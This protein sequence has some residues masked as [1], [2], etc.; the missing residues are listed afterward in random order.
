[1]DRSRIL[2]QIKTKGIP[3]LGQTLKVLRTLGQGGN[4]AA[5]LCKTEDGQELVAKIYLPPDKRE[6]DERALARFESEVKLT[7]KIRHPN[8]VR[9]LDS[10]KLTLGAYSLPFYVMPRAAKTLRDFT[11][12]YDNDPPKIEARMR[13]FLRAALGVACL[14]S[15]GIVHRD[16]K[17][18]N[19]LINKNGTP[20]V[21]DLGIAHVSP[22][23]VSV[24]VKTIASDQL[25]NRDYYA[26]E[27]RFGNATDV[28]TRADI[29]ALG[30]ILY[31]L[32]SGSPPVRSSSPALSKANE[33]FAPLDT[34]FARMTAHEPKDRYEFLEDAIEE[35]S[36]TFGWV[37]ATMK[38]ARPTTRADVPAMEK[39]IKSS[40]EAHRRSGISLAGRLGPE[41][42]PVLH[43]LIGQSRR[44]VR[45]AVAVALGEIKD[46]SS[47]PY[48]TASLYSTTGSTKASAFKPSADTAAEALSKYP[49][50]I[51]VEACKSISELIRPGQLAELLK[52]VPKDLAYDATHELIAR[53]MLLFDW[54]E[55]PFSLYAS[56]DEER[57]WPEIKK[58][59]LSGDLDDYQIRELLPH[60]SQ[61]N[62]T[63]LLRSWV[64]TP[65]KY[66]FYF[67][68]M[69]K[70]V[71]GWG[72]DAQTKSQL[73]AALAQNLSRYQPFA[74][75][76]RLE[77][78][79]SL[80]LAEPPKS[81]TVA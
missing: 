67:E 31:E 40:N 42:L 3:S 22:D 34:I 60:L 41:A 75:R 52:N 35:L 23:F 21:A 47:V 7:S 27:Q 74:K 8:V 59:A 44:V 57:A 76:A 12:S 55:T 56:L 25:L 2:N 6:L 4:G 38:G 14:H 24:G 80:L 81:E 26:P 50:K 46:L 32:L 1:M 5:L 61:A 37:L 62:R 72:T 53:K 66:S 17:P 48:L 54:S 68:D 29:Y 16:L 64:A 71:R 30:Y 45:N 70:A 10:G 63:D 13:I 11:G 51:R 49:P 73:L 36:V 33:S 77:R 58:A 9:A 43:E 65:P 15:H 19:I 79:I 39:L 18:E 78:E 20:W 28:D 69:L